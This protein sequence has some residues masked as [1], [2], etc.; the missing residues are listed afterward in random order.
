[1]P[2]TRRASRLAAE[3]VFALG[4]AAGYVEPF[5]GE[6]MAWALASAE[7]VAPLA[8]A[9]ARRWHPDLARTWAALYQR[10]VTSRQLPCRGAAA[11]L[12]HPRLAGLAVAALRRCPLLARPFVGYLNTDHQPRTPR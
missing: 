4:D 10:T 9:A 6:G 2:L 7:A 3:R 12:R 1:V 5:T 8:E 11:L